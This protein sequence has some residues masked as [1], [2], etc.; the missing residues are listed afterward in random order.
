METVLHTL[1]IFWL[2]LLVDLI[3]MA[4]FGLIRNKINLSND[5]TMQ[6]TAIRK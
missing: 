4:N 5:V 2:A 6:F 1:K 3:K